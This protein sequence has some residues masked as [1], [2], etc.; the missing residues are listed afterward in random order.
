MLKSTCPNGQ[1]YLLWTIR[2][3][4]I[5][6]VGSYHHDRENWK[7]NWFLNSKY[8][9]LELLSHWYQFTCDVMVVTTIY[10][11]HVLH[12]IRIHFTKSSW[13]QNWN[14]VK[15]YVTLTQY[16]MLRSGHNFAHVMTAVL[17]WHVQICDLIGSLKLLLKRKE[18]SIMW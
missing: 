17:A 15:T 4:D 2:R 6:S 8:I 3:W 18:I 11:H 1:L 10:C 9:N 12:M 16:I 5:L 14:F 7:W 13:A